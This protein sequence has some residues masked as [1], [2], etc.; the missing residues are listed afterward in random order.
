MSTKPGSLETE[1]KLI[2][3]WQDWSRKRREIRNEWLI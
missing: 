3:F 1:V 2:D